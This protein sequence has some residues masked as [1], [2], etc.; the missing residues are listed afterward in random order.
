M[1]AAFVQILNHQKQVFTFRLFLSVMKQTL[2][3]PTIVFS[4]KASRRADQC[5][6]APAVSLA[7]ASNVAVLPT[8]LLQMLEPVMHHLPAGR[9]ETNINALVGNRQP[10]V[11]LNRHFKQQVNI[12][13][14]VM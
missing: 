13:S 2:C 5:R 7:R 14:S 11:E 12:L 3:A 1:L 10:A 4:Y 6:G 9:L 8:F